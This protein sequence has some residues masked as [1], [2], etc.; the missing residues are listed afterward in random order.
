MEDLKQ[1]VILQIIPSLESGGVERGT[2]DIAKSLKKQNFF[3][4]VISSGGVL[5][6]DLKE[7]KITHFELNVKTKNPLTIFLNINKIAE[8]INEY[9]VD[10]VH[11]RSRAPMWS[12]YYACKKTKTKLVSTIHGTYSLDFL[13]WKNF[14]LKKTYNSIMFK[15]DS[16]I[17]VSN[18]I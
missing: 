3:P 8:I 15:A 9:K 10:I 2:I 14:S 12:A 6:Y 7:A 18:Y 11:V 5:T 1:K 13:F 4:I 16:I 17:V